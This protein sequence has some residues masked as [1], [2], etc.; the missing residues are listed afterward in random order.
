MVSSTHI[1]IRWA[2]GGTVYA[3]W[4]MPMHLMKE[5]AAVPPTRTPCVV[6]WGMAS[7]CSSIRLYRGPRG[8]VHLYR[9]PPLGGRLE[10]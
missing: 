3:P 4:A 7:S 2:S 9:F 5:M 10:L 6:P 8:I 1:I